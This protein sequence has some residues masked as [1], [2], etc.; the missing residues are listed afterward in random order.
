[1]NNYNGSVLYNEETLRRMGKIQIR[2]RVIHNVIYLAMCI[3]LIIAGIL[4]GLKTMP[5][6]LC[7]AA[8][9]IGI[10]LLG[11]VIRART[12]NI[13]K[14]LGNNTIHVSYTFDST[15]VSAS[16]GD[17]SNRILY[18]DLCML[19]EDAEYFYLF[20]GKVDT[21]MVSKKSLVPADEAGFR[22]DIAAIT[23]L[24]WYQYTSPLMINI[25]PLIQ[26]LKRTL[27]NRSR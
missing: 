19:W 13:I 26:E 12:D 17:Q 1:M 4:F 15:G 18:K 3:V 16:T 22:N 7:A 23:G 5:G 27:Q 24:T 2:S 20:Y 9:G 21:L 10:P 6:L 11:S 8:G 25:R 14:A